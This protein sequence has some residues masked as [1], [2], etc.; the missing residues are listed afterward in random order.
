V[1]EVLDDLFEVITARMANSPP[2][3]YT[4]KLFAAGRTA[5]AKKVGEEAIEVIV[6]AQSEDDARLA[7]ESADLVFHLMVLLAERG[8]Q[9][10]SVETELARR[11]ANPTLPLQP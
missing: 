3:S 10:R 4:G 7:S 9:W 8:V 6:A 5:I 11:R 2:E 1:S